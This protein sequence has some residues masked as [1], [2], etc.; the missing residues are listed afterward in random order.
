MS[1]CNCLIFQLDSSIKHKTWSIY[2]IQQQMIYLL[3]TVSFNMSCSTQQLY[4]CL[5][6]LLILGI[7]LVILHFV[8]R[9]HCWTAGRSIQLLFPAACS[10]IPNCKIHVKYL[11]TKLHT[12]LAFRRM[13]VQTC[14]WASGF[15][16]LMISVNCSRQMLGLFLSKGMVD[17]LS[18][19]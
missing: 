2:L 17:F 12:R 4:I 9:I 3:G 1:L 11:S 19:P 13:V 14:L 15:R 7:S 10:H 8:K 5:Q 6:W 16:F 18:D